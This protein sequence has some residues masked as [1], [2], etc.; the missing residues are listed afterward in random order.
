ME[1]FHWIIPKSQN[2]VIC[3]SE[4]EPQALSL[5]MVAPDFKLTADSGSQIS[6]SDYRG[7]AHVVL[8][9]VREFV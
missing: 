9:F 3:M 6:L 7:K 5:G 8:F 1:A 2:R 4:P